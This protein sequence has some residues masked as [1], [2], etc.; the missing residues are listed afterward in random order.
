[1]DLSK[2]TAT[3]SEIFLQG[4]LGGGGTGGGD[5]FGRRE[6]EIGSL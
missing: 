5:D 2:V 3:E 6:K 4:P 1:M